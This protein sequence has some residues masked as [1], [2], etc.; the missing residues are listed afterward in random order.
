MWGLRP[1][2]HLGQRREADGMELKKILH[3]SA[4][5]DHNM[6]EGD[7]GTHFEHWLWRSLE[8]PFPGRQGCGAAANGP[9]AYL[10]EWARAILHGTEAEYLHLHSD[11]QA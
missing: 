9:R 1:H 10:P 4:R 7:V 8:K 11:T 6:R 3:R 2:H 5:R